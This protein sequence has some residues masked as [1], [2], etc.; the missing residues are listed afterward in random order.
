M[1][2]NGLAAVLYG[3]SEVTAKVGDGA[4]V[5][6]TESTDYPF[7]ETIRFTISAP[8][9]VSFPLGLRIPGWCERPKISLN[10]KA[11]TLPRMAKG[12]AI[13]ERAWANGD[14]LQLELPA[15]ITVTRWAKNRNTVSVSRG[16]LTYSLRIGER[17]QAKGGTTKWPGQEVYPTTPWNYGLIVDLANPAASFEVSRKAGPLAAQPFALDA[18]PVLLRAKGRRIPQWKQEPNGMVGEVQ[19]GPVRS[20]EPVESITLVPMGCARLRISAFP[21]IG[22]GPDARTWK[23]AVPIVLA[24]SSDHFSSPAAANDEILP[25]NSADRNVPRFEWPDRSCPVQW[26]EYQWSSP[27]RISRSEVYWADDGTVRRFGGVR[28]PAAWQVTY[29][30]GSAW[31]PVSAA[32]GYEVRRDDFSRVRFS[33]V[34]TTRLRLEVSLH[35]GG[36]AGILEWRTGD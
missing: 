33:P 15:R 3:P 7:D 9:A 36:T 32:S 18:A 12:W 8:K 17:W 25:A 27:Q 30:D 16:P 31:R 20:L 34:T 13:V 23:E 10:G 6:I 11:L 35:E 4:T 21:Q 24:S 19:M 2:N 5:K 1:L 28:L 22:E 29:W 14:K 26:I